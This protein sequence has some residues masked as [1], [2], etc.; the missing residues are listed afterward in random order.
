M[1]RINIRLN[2]GRPEG[3]FARNHMVYGPTTIA[4][5]NNIIIRVHYGKR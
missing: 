3:I 5:H 2:A 4:V 1:M